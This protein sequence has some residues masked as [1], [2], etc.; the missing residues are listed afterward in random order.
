MTFEHYIWRSL[1]W[2]YD[3]THDSVCNFPKTYFLPLFLFQTRGSIPLY[4]SQYPTIKYKPK[5]LLTPGKNHV[6]DIHEH[7]VVFSVKWFLLKASWLQGGVCN[8][9]HCVTIW[10][11][12]RGVVEGWGSFFLALK[13][14]GNCF[15]SV[16]KGL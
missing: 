8:S 11:M 5:P 16:P 2:W 10:F 7:I 15:K 14:L 1:F 4:W 6:S 13:Y 3:I 9:V 12:W